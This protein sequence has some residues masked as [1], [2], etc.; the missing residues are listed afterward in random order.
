ML[1]TNL[2]R[3]KSSLE[4]NSQKS[5]KETAL[6]GELKNVESF[7]DRISFRVSPEDPPDKRVDSDAQILRVSPQDSITKR[8]GP[9]LSVDIECPHCH[10]TFKI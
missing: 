3:L 6:L 2:N 1:P 5:I 4:S 8:V 7:L 10:K 9:D